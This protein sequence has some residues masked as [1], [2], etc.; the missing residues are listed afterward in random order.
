M[1]R[2][3]ALPAKTRREIAAN[4]ASL[5]RAA[6]ADIE[7]RHGW[8]AALSARDRASVALVAHSGIE[9]FVAWLSDES[10]VQVPAQ[11]LFDAAPPEL[12][13]SISLAQ[14]LDLIRSVVDVVEVQ[15]AELVGPETAPALLE[16]MLRYSRD[17][18]F[19]AA[20]I[21]ARA[22]EQ[23][24][25]WDARL[26][27][28]V[29]DA[30]LRGDADDSIQSRA[31]ALGWGATT[32]VAVVAG[33]QPEA[34]HA[35]A[36][37]PPL[38]LDRLHRAAARNRLQV[39]AALQGGR[40]IVLI[41]ETADALRDAALLTD[42]FGAGP[43]VVGPTVPHLFAA[44]RSARAAISGQAAA[45]AWP[46]APRP[47]PASELLAERALIGDMPARSALVTRIVRPLAEAGGG[48]LLRTATAYLD[49]GRNLEA[50]ARVLFVHPNTV[51]YRLGRIAELTGYD[52][53][54]PHDADTVH[55]AI[56]LGRLA[57][58][59]ISGTASVARS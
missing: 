33:A 25:A 19:G 35:V 16:A 31:A 9:N 36:I 54:D 11:A 34:D 57:E 50:T 24:G 37:D 49:G 29:V 23:R 52:L 53:G 27:G 45:A 46:D 43:L 7:A 6:V 2:R 30:I 42:C 10:T 28:L 32:R 38:V 59:G 3:A 18:A 39:L 47:A 14:T 40:L 17:V 55:L 26:E 13:R 20:H 12:T 22:A 21:Y 56:R 4:T 15:A 44:G 51:R 58:A 5:V 48:E 1:P 8:Y 41:G